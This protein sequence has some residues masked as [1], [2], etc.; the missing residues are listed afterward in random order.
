MPPVM[1]AWSASAVNSGARGEQ[2][3]RGLVGD[4]EIAQPGDGLGTD[5]RSVARKHDHDIVSGQ[6]LA[7]DHQGMSGA[8]L[9]ILNHKADAG[10]RD[11]VANQ[12]RFVADDGVDILGGNDSGGSPDDMGDER[13]AADLVQDLRMF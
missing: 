2:R 13:L 12:F 8:A 5:E 7:G 4:V 6:N 9:G 10:V 11:C 1:T 3:H